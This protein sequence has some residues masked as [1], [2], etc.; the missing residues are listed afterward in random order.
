MWYKYSCHFLPPHFHVFFEQMAEP[1]QNLHIANMTATS[2]LR[3][4]SANSIPSYHQ[5]HHCHITSAICHQYTAAPPHKLDHCCHITVTT[6]V[7][8]PSTDTVII[9]G[10]LFPSQHLFC[11]WIVST[12]HLCSLPAASAPSLRDSSSRG[13]TI[14]ES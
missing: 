4:T 3:V 11:H 6:T 12:Q 13:S 9:V 2:T 8:I 10:L 7:T 5:H 14:Q 1:N